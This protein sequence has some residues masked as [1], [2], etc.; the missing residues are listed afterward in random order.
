MQKIL[1]ST[2]VASLLCLNACQPNLDTKDIT[3][4]TTSAPPDNHP[5]IQATTPKALTKALVALSENQLTNE[6]ICAK[7]SESMQDVDN[8]SD[9]EDIHSIQRQLEACLPLADNPKIIQW[10]ADYQAMYTRFLHVDYD[11]DAQTFYTIM[12]LTEQD[13]KAPLELLRK[14]SPRIRYLVMLVEDEADVSVQYLG[15]GDYRFHHNLQAM[16]DLFTPYLP[17]DQVAFIGRMAM[18]N[19]Q[20]FWFD[21]AIAFS[22]DELIERT[23]FWEA[24]T[25]QYPDSY[26]IDD[27]SALFNEYRHLVFFG[28]ENTQWT[29]DSIR[30]FYESRDKQTMEEVAEIPNQ[31]LAK[32]AQIF[33]DFMTLSDSERQRKYPVSRTDDGHKRDERALAYLQLTQALSLT[34]P[35]NR[36]NKNCSAGVIC[37]DND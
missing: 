12:S 21:A 30:E 33:L 34:S 31:I 36:G 1:L 35:W 7:L 8:T 37:L 29:T 4:P 19:Q 15:E 28:S 25:R 11:A 20:I 13:I 23:L 3:P 27:A 2:I 32:D 26:F 24:H 14:T 17:A 5:L 6:L 9:I 16:A 18:D 10:L 22:F